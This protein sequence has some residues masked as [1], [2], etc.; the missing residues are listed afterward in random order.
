MTFLFDLDSTITKCE[1][2]PLL[3]EENG[4]RE[5]MAARTERSMAGN[6]DFAADFAARVELLRPVPLHRA[7]EI[8][9]NAPVHGEIAA[10]L[11][12]HRDR[13]WIVTGNLD[14]WISGLVRRL[15]MEGRCLCSAAETAGDRLL[16]IRSILD[17][18]AAARQ[19]AHPFAAIGDGSND[20]G[21]LR[22]ADV[23][24]AFG[25]ARRIS[26]ELRSAADMVFEDE[27]ALCAFLR[28]L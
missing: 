28:T 17:K 16:G 4:L 26:D 8:I 13:C 21:M 10:F 22:A 1:L 7:R 12:E 2:L 14:A 6:G 19:F 3:A 18:A 24:I 27:I 23:G 9:E 5:E 11:R 25:G 15:G 20:A